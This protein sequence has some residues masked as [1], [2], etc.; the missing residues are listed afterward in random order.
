MLTKLKTKQI[1]GCLS[2]TAIVPRKTSKNRSQRPIKKKQMM[3]NK[4]KKNNKK[5]AQC[6]T[7]KLKRN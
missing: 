3:N 6:Q 1:L 4:I 5:K 7:R 2:K